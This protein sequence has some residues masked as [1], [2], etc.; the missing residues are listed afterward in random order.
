LLVNIICLPFAKLG[1]NV[2]QGE[3][4]EHILI[5]LQE[6]DRSSLGNAR[7]E[8]NSAWILSERGFSVTIDV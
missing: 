5:I 6:W 2:W 1:K 8:E 4:I 7:N 3:V